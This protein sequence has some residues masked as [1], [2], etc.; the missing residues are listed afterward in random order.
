MLYDH[1]CQVDWIW[2]WRQTNGQVQGGRRGQPPNSPFPACKSKVSYNYQSNHVK[3]KLWIKLPLFYFSKI[4][5]RKNVAYFYAQQLN[6]HGQEVV[7]L[8]NKSLKLPVHVLPKVLPVSACCSH[9]LPHKVLVNFSVVTS[10]SWWHMRL[11]TFLWGIYQDSN[12]FCPTRIST[13]V[14]KYTHSHP[15]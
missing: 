15:M 2:F 14:S 4:C 9:I 1:H 10:W 8:V 6:L 11:E 5:E 13:S 12:I 7:K 3:I